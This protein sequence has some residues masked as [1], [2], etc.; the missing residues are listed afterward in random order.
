MNYKLFIEEFITVRDKDGKRKQLNLKDV[1]K[2][3]HNIRGY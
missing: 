1:L 2:Q 3:A